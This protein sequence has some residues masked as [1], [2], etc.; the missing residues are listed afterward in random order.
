MKK[1]KNVAGQVG[2]LESRPIALSISATFGF[3][4]TLA[5]WLKILLHII[6]E[7]TKYDPK[8]DNRALTLSEALGDVFFL[9]HAYIHVY[10]RPTYMHG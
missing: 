9:I 7:L 3:T 5:K 6:I 1:P 2:G 4:L 8:K 10:T